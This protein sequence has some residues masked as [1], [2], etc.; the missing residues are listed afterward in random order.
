MSRSTH[1]RQLLGR[2]Q[3]VADQTQKA[4]LKALETLNSLE[5]TERREQSRTSNQEA[6]L[7]R[8]FN[9]EERR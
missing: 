5:D 9:L 7:R 3:G 8:R 1:L 6:D 4:R 2:A